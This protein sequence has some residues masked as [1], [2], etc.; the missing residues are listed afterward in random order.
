MKRQTMTKAAILAPLL[1]L[2][3]GQETDGRFCSEAGCEFSEWE[4]KQL[5]G[6][7]DLPEAPPADPSNKYVGNPL[8]VAIGHKFFYD[9][10]FSGP[11][12]NQDALKRPTSH[13]RAPTGQPA[14]VSCATCHDYRKGGADNTSVPGNVSI[15][16][17]W[18]DTNSPPT[19]NAAFYGIVYWNGRAD[20]LWAQAVSSNEG[21]NLNGNR[22]KTAYLIKD[23]YEAE[24]NAA[25][26][27]HPLPITA[28]SDEI[29]ALVETSGENAGQCKLEAGACPT[30]K[31]CR[32]VHEEGV[33]SCWPRFPLQGRP[34]SKQGCQAGLATEPFRDAFDCMDDAD[35]DAVTRVLVNWAKAIAA[36][37]WRLV[38]RNAPFDRFVS[39]TRQHGASGELS[40]AARR[41]ARLFVGKAACVDCHNTPLMSD[42]Q[43]HNIGVAQVGAGV[44]TEGDCPDESPVCDCVENPSAMS[45]DPMLGVNNCLPW[46]AR[47]GLKK[48]RSNAFRRD[49]IWSDNPGDSSRK[50]YMERSLAKVGKGTWRTPT[51]RD[52]ALTAPYMHNGSLAT[53][54]EVVHHYNVGGSSA[55]GARNAR[56]KP[57]FLTAEE[58]Q[59]LVAFLKSLTGSGIPA[60]LAVSPNVPE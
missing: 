17:G 57:L 23:L 37:E 50:D 22:L 9:E 59:D 58:Q 10:K 51:L 48:L 5:S 25:F 28:K 41:G 3:C 45:D 4:W 27:D 26:V 15:G 40:P 49:S 54:E 12:T 42:S 20:S 32:Q 14:K 43:F 46:G 31:G 29:E 52:V 19:T 56:I 21:N 33:S 36:Y 2:G 47:D 7:A 35:R 1:L 24:Y 8:A 11:A 38:S 55:A 60:D 34:G 39:Q 30:A 6:L 18:S 16:A 44:P 53:L 13:G